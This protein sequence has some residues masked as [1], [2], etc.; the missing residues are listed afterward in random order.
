MIHLATYWL[1]K[2]MVLQVI[3]LDA[4]DS[5]LWYRLYMIPCMCSGGAWMYWYILACTKGELNQRFQQVL[6][7]SMDSK[8]YTKEGNILVRPLPLMSKGESD[9]VWLLPSCPKGE[10]VG[11]MIQVFSMMATHSEVWY[12]CFPW[13]KLTHM[14]DHS[15]IGNVRGIRGLTLMKEC[16]H[17]S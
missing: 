15:A 8:R 6:K 11:I 16:I 14:I 10:I 9:L 5:C 13:W 4:N 1:V 7:G 12:R 2:R 17:V 3:G